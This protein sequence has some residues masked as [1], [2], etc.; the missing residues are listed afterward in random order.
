V[1]QLSGDGSGFFDKG[2][3]PKALLPVCNQNHRPQDP[4][5]QIEQS[6]H[7]IL[8]AADPAVKW[9]PTFQVFA[10]RF[11]GPCRIVEFRID[12]FVV[13]QQPRQDRTFS[14]RPA[15]L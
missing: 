5:E 15:R 12:T 6:G 11:A 14:G 10:H 4:G 3:G 7:P 8:P 13:A 2:F 1:I 9:K